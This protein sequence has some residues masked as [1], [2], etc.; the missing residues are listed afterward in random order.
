MLAL[1]IEPKSQQWGVLRQNK[2]QQWVVPIVSVS[3]L[4]CYTPML[5]RPLGFEH[6]ILY[7]LLLAPQCKRKGRL[8]V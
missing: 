3:S 8:R 2:G 6:L 7:T 5:K 4:C 1:E